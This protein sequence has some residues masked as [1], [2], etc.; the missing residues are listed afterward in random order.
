MGNLFP[1]AWRKARDATAARRDHHTDERVINGRSA[2]R[3]AT[4][5][6]LNCYIS[7]REGSDLENGIQRTWC[8]TCQRKGSDKYHVAEIQPLVAV[9]VVVLATLQAEV[10]VAVLVVVSKY[11][12]ELGKAQ[13]AVLIP[14][15]LRVPCAA[16]PSRWGEQ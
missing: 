8:G 3:A 10:L 14:V 15:A 6:R 1:V 4:T 16:P 2:L 11:L 12:L 5:S 7:H 9:I 13:L